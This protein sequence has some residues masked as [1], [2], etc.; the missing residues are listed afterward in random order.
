MILLFLT[1]YVFTA[2]FMFV[3][4]FGWACFLP[5]N[6]PTVD[7]CHHHRPQLLPGDGMRAHT[8]RSCEAMHE[9]RVHSGRLQGISVQLSSSLA[10][11]CGSQ[12][13][14]LHVPT[15]HCH[16]RRTPRLCSASAAPPQRLCS[17]SAAHCDHT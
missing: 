4:Y 10:R 11:H 14:R 5:V 7:S 16:P 6:T 17:A 9:G 2:P 3:S 1:L 13:P 15:H 12:Q 8:H